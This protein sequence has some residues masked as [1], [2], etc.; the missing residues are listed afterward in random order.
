MSLGLSG[1]RDGLGVLSPMATG[2]EDCS[3]WSP[4]AFDHIGT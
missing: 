4:L 2:P 1:C 3:S